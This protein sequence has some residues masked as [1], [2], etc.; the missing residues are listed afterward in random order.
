MMFQVHSTPG[1][2]DSRPEELS[3]K[4]DHIAL[5]SKWKMQVP[6]SAVSQVQL[7]EERLSRFGGLGKPMVRKFHC[8]VGKVN[9]S[10]EKHYRYD[11]QL[12][13]GECV[14]SSSIRGPTW[15]RLMT[16]IYFRVIQ[17]ADC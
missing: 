13:R 11:I 15:R 7:R 1:D 10:H 5:E 16:G 14:A 3:G 2:S 8:S 6:L 4:M 12:F 9:C 17:L